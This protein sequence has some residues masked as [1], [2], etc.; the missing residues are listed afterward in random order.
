VKRLAVCSVLLILAVGIPLTTRAVATATCTWRVTDPGSVRGHL[1][2]VASVAPDDAWAVGFHY[3]QHHR[4]HGRILHWDGSSW[5]R[6]PLPSGS[7]WLTLRATDGVATDDVWAVGET[8]PGNTGASLAIFHWDGLEWSPVAGPALND[9]RIWS[10]EAIAADDVWAVGYRYEVEGFY[11]L[12][13][14]WDG[15]TWSEV[16]NPWDAE[17]WTQ[18]RGVS[19][20]ADDDVWAVGGDLTAPVAMHW[21]GSTWTEFPT[22]DLVSTYNSLLLDVVAVTPTRAWAVGQAHNGRYAL[23]E[24]WNGDRWSRAYFSRREGVQ[25]AV[26]VSA[27]S[28]HEVWAAAFQGAYPTFLRWDGSS[29]IKDPVPVGGLRSR[30]V[31]ALDSLP[32]GETFGVGNVDNLKVFAVDRCVAPTA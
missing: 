2:D 28:R 24:R 20:V 1:F 19:G 22:A 5:T 31:F 30:A 26:S 11:A 14:H 17:L 27:V 15:T 4:E 29:W 8:R 9:P 21:D 32:S 3:D 23:I 6:S 12:A 18:L 10:V 13:L 25:T 16:P 7:G